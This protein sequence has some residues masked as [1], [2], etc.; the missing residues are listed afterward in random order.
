MCPQSR[1]AASGLGGRPGR[2]QGPH[3]GRRG[4]RDAGFAAAWA[5]GFPRL[6]P[7]AAMTVTA[8]VA[9]FE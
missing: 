2:E 4:T 7:G 6:M 8:Q 3:Q 9:V 1:Q 5:V